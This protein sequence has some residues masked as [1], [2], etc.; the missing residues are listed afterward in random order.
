M[1]PTRILDQSSI[2]VKRPISSLSPIPYPLSS[3]KMNPIFSSTSQ[4]IIWLQ[5]IWYDSPPI[6]GHVVLDPQFGPYASFARIA[7]QAVFPQLLFSAIRDT[8]DPHLAQECQDVSDEQCFFPLIEEVRQHGAFAGFSLFQDGQRLA[9]VNA[10]GVPVLGEE[11]D[12]Q[13]LQGLGGALENEQV[14]CRDTL[15]SGMMRFLEE[16]RAKTVILSRAD[17]EQSPNLLMKTM[18]E[19]DAFFG[20]DGEG[21]YCFRATGGRV[22]PLWTICFLLD[23]WGH[24]IGQQRV[25]RSGKRAKT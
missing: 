3:A 23:D 22:D 1:S 18:Q 8:P 21:R 10:Q 20:F 17:W 9:L 4:Y 12:R 25:Q 13:I 11:R 19:Q 2:R 5:E 24:R 14:V 6:W 7:L 15:S 16:H